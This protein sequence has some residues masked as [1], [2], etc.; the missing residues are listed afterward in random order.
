MTGISV[1]VPTKDRL[2]YLH[3]AVAI[4]LSHAEVGE[5]IVVVDGC[6]DQTLE[7]VETAS[8]ADERVRYVD[9]KRNMGL[10]YSRN[11]GIEL[12]ECEYVFTGEDDLEL[13]DR[14]FAKLLDHMEETGADIISGRNIFKYEGESNEESIDRTHQLGRSAIDRW[15][16][17]VQPGIRTVDDEEQTLLPAPML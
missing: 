6:R 13:S 5:V 3:R 17:T 2:P 16:I 14:F 8:A 7:Y 12:A 15:A 11:R 4:F 10:P 1:V 9:N